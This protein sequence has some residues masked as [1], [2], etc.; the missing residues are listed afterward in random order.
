MSDKNAYFNEPKVIA[1][2]QAL[3][4]AQCTI[5]DIQP[6]NL[7][8]KANGEL[9]FA[10]LKVDASTPEGYK[11]PQ[12]AFIRGHACIIVPLIINNGTGENRFV[13]VRQRRIACG[14]MSLEF[15]AGMLDRDIHNPITVAMNELFE[16]TGLEINHDTLFPLSNKLLYTSPG[17]CDEGIYYY[18]CITKVNNKTFYSFSGSKRG[19]RSENEYIQV[20]LKTGIEIESKVTSLPALLGYLLFKK[21][22]LK[23]KIDLGFE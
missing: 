1:W 8:R 13:M 21:Y 2:K 17:A 20:D 10:L 11:I 16:E 18:G 7:F 22:C 3:I 5:H 14:D 15:P 23:N 9:L 6:L 12:I 4:Q 19:N